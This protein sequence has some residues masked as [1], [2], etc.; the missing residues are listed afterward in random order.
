LR[1]PCQKM[2]RYN[3]LFVMPT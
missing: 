1:Q 3:E 2:H